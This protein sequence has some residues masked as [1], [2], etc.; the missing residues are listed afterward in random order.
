VSI[1][2][3]P[4]ISQ[5]VGVLVVLGSMMFSGANPTLGQLEDNPLLGRFMFY[6]SY[7]SFIRY[8]QELY[9][10]I[11]IKMY[12]YGGDAMTTLYQYSLTDWGSCWM[13]LISISFVVRLIAYAALVKHEK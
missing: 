1:I 2:V 12:P 13:W 3:R 7:F 11:E 6:P 9:Y 10:L 4:S 8:A 5:L